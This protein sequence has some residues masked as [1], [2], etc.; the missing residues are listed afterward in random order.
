M[1][2]S[3]QFKWHDTAPTAEYSSWAG[4]GG[5]PGSRT[6][7]Q[8][9]ER[10][11]A[12]LVSTIMTSVSNF[13]VQFNIQA[14]SVALVI[15]SSSVC[16]TDKD[17]CKKGEQDGWVLSTAEAM[18]FVG[19]ITGQLSMGYLGDALGRSPALKITLS[20]VGIGALGSGLLSLGDATSI[21]AVIILFRF[22]LGIGVGGVYP[23]S[24]TKAA[25]DAAVSGS[26]EVNSIASAKVFFWQAPGQTIPSVI[27]LAMA[28]S[29]IST[30][31]K[32]RL[33]L[34]VGAIPAFIVVALSV[35]EER[36]L[37]A[38]DDDN[39][40]NLSAVKVVP[41][42][43]SEVWV[44]MKDPVITRKLIVSGGGWFLYD[45]CFY[46]MELFSPYILDELDGGTNNVSSSH[47]IFE[48]CWRNT[49]ALSLAIPA[50]ILTIYMMMRGNSMRFLQISGFLLIAACFVL[51]AILW[52][53]LGDSNPEALYGIYCVLLFA[54]SYGPN[55]TTFTLPATMYPKEIRSTMNGVSAAMGKLGAVVGVYIFSNLASVV[56]FEVIMGLCTGVAALGA[57]IT[58]YYLDAEEDTVKRKMNLVGSEESFN[59]LVGDDIVQ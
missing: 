7:D 17:D 2:I 16:T 32:W 38:R 28:Y 35:V 4:E 27:G 46:G 5:S 13:S 8:A 15:M 6:A 11:I 44:L 41:P 37:A 40:K 20:C 43:I 57:Y 23:L 30:E 26:D 45:V 54:L 21:Y 3:D 51:L 53:P 12:K 29:D 42:G 14:L 56:D 49:I 10:D 59:P 22:I 18:V 39:K 31:L 36:I 1:S 52:T 48:K 34:A 19:A 58:W 9:D 50:C 24:A 47:S 55:T 33:M 25:E